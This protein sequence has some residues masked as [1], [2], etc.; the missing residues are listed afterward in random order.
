MYQILTQPLFYYF[1]LICAFASPSIFPIKCWRS[2][3][4]CAGCILI[5]TVY[6]RLFF[7]T[8]YLNCYI[9]V[10]FSPVIIS[11]E[12]QTHLNAIKQWTQK[13]SIVINKNKTCHITIFLNKLR[14]PEVYFNSQKI[15]PIE[16]SKYFVIYLDQKLTG[17]IYIITK[18]KQIKQNVEDLNR[19]IRRKSIMSLDNNLYGCIIL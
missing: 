10:L 15:P 2:T 19:L 12:L 1:I 4:Q 18:I 5:F 13:W 6:Q 11:N 9:A 3:R 7:T 16:N 17:K 14:C 8:R